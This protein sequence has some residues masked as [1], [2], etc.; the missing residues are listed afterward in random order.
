MHK[1]PISTLIL[2]SLFSNM[3]LAEMMNDDQLEL[4]KHQQTG[5]QPVVP[6]GF[7]TFLRFG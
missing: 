6:E 7:V 4:L 5:I 1:A 3:M 2:D